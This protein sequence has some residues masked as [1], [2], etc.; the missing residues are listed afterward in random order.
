MTIV[1]NVLAEA[2]RHRV[3]LAVSGDKVVWGGRHGR[4]PGNFLDRLEQHRAELV[5][6]LNAGLDA[7][8]YRWWSGCWDMHM[9]HA[10]VGCMPD[11]WRKVCAAAEAF[12][13]HW[14]VPAYWLGWTLHDLFAAHCRAPFARLDHV[15]LA[16][17]LVG[18]QVIDMTD[19]EAV[20]SHGNGRHTVFRKKPDRPCE[21]VP[22]WTVCDPIQPHQW[23]PGDSGE[24]G[25]WTRRKAPDWYFWLHEYHLR[26]RE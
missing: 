4:P 5:A 8:L 22:V 11:Q 24:A 23:W 6:G 3:R 15:G 14:G 26:G 16:L 12:L 9:S 17:R 2:E 7:E 1:K 13:D 18:K 20:I 19:T 25:G 10:P 21:F